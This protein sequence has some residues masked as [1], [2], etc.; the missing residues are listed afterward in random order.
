MKQLICMLLLFVSCE[1]FSQQMVM[2]SFYSD[3]QEIEVLTEGLDEI[4]I[5]NSKN[6]EIEITLFDE[7]LNAHYILIDDE[8][9][10]L[11]IGFKLHF[12]KNET[13]FR[14]FITNRLNR[15]SVVLKLPKNK[16]L[17]LNGTNIDIISKNYQGNLKIYIDKGFINLNEIQQ[18]AI[19]KLFKGNVFAKTL[20]S[21]IDIQS[22]NGKIVVNNTQ[23]QKKYQKQEI[24]K[25][26][27]FELISINANIVLSTK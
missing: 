18:N 5:V 14:K 3:A 26:K 27:T 20:N 15:A 4:K 22:N 11:K 19:L 13:V 9:P 24:K 12:F 23:F 10:I 7:N 16:N 25:T 1:N 6:K 21:N 17:T 2:K 8:T